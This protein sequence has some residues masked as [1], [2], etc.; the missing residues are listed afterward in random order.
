MAKRSNEAKKLAGLIGKH[1][2]AP[3]DGSVGGD[4]QAVIN[5]LNLHKMSNDHDAFPH[6]WEAIQKF[7]ST[8]FT[9]NI[10]P[11]M[12]DA[13]DVGSD[14]SRFRKGFFSELSTIIFKKEN[15]V[16][17]D[18]QFL[19][20]K[21]AG[22][23]DLAVAAADTR[24][25]FGRV[26]QNGDFVLF[27]SEGKMEYIKVGTLNT[28]TRYNVTRN[29]DGSGANDW[30]EGEPFAVLGKSGEGWLEMT[31]VDSDRLRFSVWVQGS[32]Y[33]NSLE[34]VRLGKIDGWQN[35]GLAGFGLAIGNYASGKYLTYTESGGLKLAG[36]EFRAGNMVFDEDGVRFVDPNVYSSGDP[37][38]FVDTDGKEFFS[39][40][41][42]STQVGAQR[43]TIG[44][45]QLN[46]QRSKGDA[47]AQFRHILRWEKNAFGSYDEIDFSMYI[48]G[49]GK[50]AGINAPL[51]V[52]S[53]DPPLSNEAVTKAYVDTIQGRYVP[54]IAPAIVLNGV[55]R[56]VGNYTVNVSPYGVP[57]TASG[58]VLR[59]SAQWPVAASASLLVLRSTTAS[60][61]LLVVRASTNLI[62][63]GNGVVPIN[64]G[65]FVYSV[66]GANAATVYIYITGYFT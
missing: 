43:A 30:G 11:L 14:T 63:D 4:V 59:V 42:G 58:L 66:I 36:A 38:R 9:S 28:G 46:N 37:I 48:D 40:S 15:V 61:A 47:F 13:F 57:A 64:G 52:G 50:Y 39:I 6:D 35:A 26:M 25:D 18:G 54:L 44:Q 19:V 34:M 21:M 53:N 16:I 62:Q 1:S 49:N 51:L 45:M 23:L 56:N 55:A 24:I 41:G 22:K 5:A 8:I 10:L 27:R 3:L 31:A 60:D 65:S 12:P 2:D 17:M 33:N 20:T 29:L 7:L 32:A